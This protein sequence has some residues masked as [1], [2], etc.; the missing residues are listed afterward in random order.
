LNYDQNA[1]QRTASVA[2]T[3][4]KCL[5]SMTAEVDDFAGKDSE[6]HFAL[7]PE[8]GEVR[9]AEGAIHPMAEELQVLIDR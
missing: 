8:R 5:M 7:F 9:G 6:P 1:R 2:K 3:K 4:E